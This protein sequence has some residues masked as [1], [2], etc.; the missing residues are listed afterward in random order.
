MSISEII[1]QKYKRQIKVNELKSPEEAAQVLI[2]D[3]K[4]FDVNNVAYTEGDPAK[5]Q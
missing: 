3:T 4:Q 1:A 5:Q 2:K